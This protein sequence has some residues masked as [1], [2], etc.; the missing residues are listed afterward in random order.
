M[1]IPKGFAAELTAIAEGT[2]RNVLENILTG[3][4]PRVPVQTKSVPF[5]TQPPAASYPRFGEVREAKYGE[6]AK[7]KSP[8]SRAPASGRYE[9]L[10]YYA[11]SNHRPG[12][13]RHAMV[14]A[15]T[16]SS[17]DFDD[18]TEKR[19]SSQKLAL[20]YLKEHFPQHFGKGIDFSWCASVEY[21][22]F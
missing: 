4:M 1:E 19:Y 16:K 13:W 21:I 18:E 9:V 8:R 3:L 17:H 5:G 15:A 12:T 10:N 2:P 14:A 7:M 22:K 6:R 11:A 20:D